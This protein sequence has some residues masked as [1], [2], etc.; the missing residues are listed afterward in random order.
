MAMH[1]RTTRPHRHLKASIANRILPVHSYCTLP[2]ETP[3]AIM[4]TSSDA[5]EAAQFQAARQV[6]Q[7]SLPATVSDA[8]QIMTCESFVLSV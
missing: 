3:G 7:S 4:S 5:V 2:D 6:R 8:L 1:G